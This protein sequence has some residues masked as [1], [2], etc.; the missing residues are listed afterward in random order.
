MTVQ[1]L[2]NILGRL[3]PE[4]RKIYGHVLTEY[5]HI[6]L[7]I[8]K[9][10]YVSE[11]QLDR[12]LV[13]QAKL[14]NDLYLYS[15]TTEDKLDLY[16]AGRCD[17]IPPDGMGGDER[18]GTIL[19]TDEEVEIGMYPEKAVYNFKPCTC[20]V[21]EFYTTDDRFH[22]V[23]GSQFIE[24]ALHAQFCR[25]ASGVQS[26]K[27]LKMKAVR[28]ILDNYKDKIR[29]RIIEKV[30]Y[31]LLDVAVQRQRKLNKSLWVNDLR[32]IGFSPEKY[33]SGKY[34]Y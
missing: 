21:Y 5:A 19:P 16:F 2:N 18:N 26:P 12:M 6:S 32:S 8:E 4:Q 3:T 17:L 15:L 13:K 23:G 7:A 1:E 31:S 33:E 20:G 25:W 24:W 22:Y 30:P 14:C 27:K 9:D 34:N 28:Y 29:F 10:Q 11:Y